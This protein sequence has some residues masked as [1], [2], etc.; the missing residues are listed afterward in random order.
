MLPLY[1]FSYLTRYL[2]INYNIWT[3]YMLNLRQLVPDVFS[4]R[5]D[6]RSIYSAPRICDTSGN[7]KPVT[8]D[9]YINIHG[10]L[11]FVN[12]T[13]YFLVF[14]VSAISFCIPRD[15]SVCAQTYLQ[16]WLCVGMSQPQTAKPSHLF[17]VNC[18]NTSHRSLPHCV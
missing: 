6:D 12:Q 16:G 5:L 18:S 15:A 11:Q 8:S 13:E 4:I 3:W 2:E 9:I 14:M 1:Q 10:H 7:Y 17:I